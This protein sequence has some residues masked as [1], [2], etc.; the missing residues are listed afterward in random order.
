MIPRPGAVGPKP[1]SAG[2][3]QVIDLAAA[4]LAPPPPASRSGA[5]SSKVFIRP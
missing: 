2:K 1:A 5:F 4:R 3:V